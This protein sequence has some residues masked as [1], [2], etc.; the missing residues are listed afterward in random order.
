MDKI[1][2]PGDEPLV[3]R[4]KKKELPKPWTTRER[5]VVAGAFF[6]LMALSGIL[7][8]SARAWKLPGWPRLGL[9]H[10]PS[11]SLFKEGTIVLESEEKQEVDMNKIKSEKIISDFNKDV[12]DQAGVYGLY[13]YDL[14]TNYNFGIN[15]NEVFT[16]ASVIKLPVMIGMMGK[17]KSLV[18]RMG[19]KS[20]NA[21][22]MEARKILGDAKIDEIA[23]NLGMTKTKVGPNETSPSDVGTFFV[24]EKDN[25]ELLGYLTDTIFEQH[26]KAG[27]P[28]EVRV[29]HKYGREVNV[30]NDGGIV[31]AVHPYVVV[32]MSKGVILSKADLLF[33]ALSKIVYDGM[34]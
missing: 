25:T 7:A 17:D 24:K 14:T 12:A 32:I 9:P 5:S 6:V 33:P 19:K 29:A 8:M 1:T 13:V 4:H 26:L 30:V 2:P 11:L 15:E 16:A 31:Y 23:K 27:V 18:E 10:L 20:D 28:A 3:R 21:A 34:Q 22:F